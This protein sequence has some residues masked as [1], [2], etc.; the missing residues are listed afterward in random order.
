MNLFEPDH[1]MQND[2]PKARRRA[3]EDLSYIFW[4]PEN[5]S[6]LWRMLYPPARPKFNDGDLVRSVATRA[7]VL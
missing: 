2:G 6:F 4:G 1:V 3:Q 5:L 7:R